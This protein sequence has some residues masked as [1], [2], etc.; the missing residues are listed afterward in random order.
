MELNGLAEGNGDKEGLGVNGERRDAQVSD[1]VALVSRRGRSPL[2]EEPALDH[3][4]TVAAVSIVRVPV[5]ALVEGREQLPVSTE[6]LALSC[7]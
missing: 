3:T 4:T 6:F 7:V 1:L 5:I 2:T